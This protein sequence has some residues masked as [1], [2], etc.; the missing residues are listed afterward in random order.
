MNWWR[1]RKRYPGSGLPGSPVRREE[2][3]LYVYSKG[4]RKKISEI[5][6][7][8]HAR[9]DVG[10]LSWDIDELAERPGRLALATGI[11]YEGRTL[12]LYYQPLMTVRPDTLA[13]RRPLSG[14]SRG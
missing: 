2:R 3:W 10:L 1:F 5:C 9:L 12:P 8:H 11:E 13:E 7:T 4:P 6:R 14:S